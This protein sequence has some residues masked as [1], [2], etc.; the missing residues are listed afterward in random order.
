MLWIFL[1]FASKLNLKNFHINFVLFA[2]LIELPAFFEV[3]I[4][5]EYHFRNMTGNRLKR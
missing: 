1:L 3:L 2:Y 4:N 5:K